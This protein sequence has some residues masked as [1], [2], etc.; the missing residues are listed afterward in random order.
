MKVTSLFITTM[1]L[2]IWTAQVGSGIAYKEGLRWL[3]LKIVEVMP[4]VV[5][6]QFDHE[7]IACLAENI[8]YEARGESVAGKIAVTNVVLN[9]VTDGRFPDT[10]CR[11][12]HQR[13]SAGCQ[14]S[15]VCFKNKPKIDVLQ[16]GTPSLHTIAKDVYLNK[17]PDMTGGATYYHETTTH[18]YW[19]KLFDKT[20]VIGQH[21]FYSRV[22]T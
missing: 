4:E 5:L 20:K 2:I 8:Y 13:S 10:P 12:V 15:W 6:T 22:K 17:M 3:D 11:V 14:F 19:R 18:P 9:R 1:L 16:L 7:Q 21:I